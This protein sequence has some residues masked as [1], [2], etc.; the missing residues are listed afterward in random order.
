MNS[1]DRRSGRAT[2]LEELRRIEARINGVTPGPEEALDVGEAL[3]AF[4][5]RE[6]D[7]LSPLAPLLDPAA[8]ADLALE[9]QQLGEDLTLLDWLVRTAPES[10]DVAL[11]TTS[12]VRRMRIHVDRDGRLLA[13]AEGLKSR[14]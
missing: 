6:E 1:P 5:R 3:L 2:L 10:P 8:Q 9:H 4:A 14:R 12:L 7:A 13:R 11:L